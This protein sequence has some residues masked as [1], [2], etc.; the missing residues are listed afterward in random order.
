MTSNEVACNFGKKRP[1]FRE[2]TTPLP[3]P[4]PAIKYYE[5]CEKVGRDYRIPVRFYQKVIKVCK[6]VED[7][8]KFPWV[9]SKKEHDQVLGP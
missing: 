5:Y 3:T 1:L 2:E 4:L 9:V 6:R 8:D 7:T